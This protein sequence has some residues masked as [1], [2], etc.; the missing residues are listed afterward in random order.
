M[1]DLEGRIIKTL[2]DNKQAPGYK[3]ISWDATNYLGNKVS[4]GIY[5]YRMETESFSQT[6]KMVLLKWV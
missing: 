3:S 5:F 4:S 2:L 6:N 1:F